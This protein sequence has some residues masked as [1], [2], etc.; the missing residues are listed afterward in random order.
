MDFARL[1]DQIPVQRAAR[2]SYQGAQFVSI[3]KVLSAPQMKGA[4]KVQ[5]SLTTDNSLRTQV[6]AFPPKPCSTK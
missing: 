2:T 3:F 1:L 6:Q 4:I 5:S